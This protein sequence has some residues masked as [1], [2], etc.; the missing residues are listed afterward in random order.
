M[1]TPRNSNLVFVPVPSETHKWTPVI[2]EFTQQYLDDLTSFDDEAKMKL[3]KNLFRSW[4]DC[5]KCPVRKDSVLYDNRRPGERQRL[6][7]GNCPYWDNQPS[8]TTVD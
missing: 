8:K 7:N 3:V 4:T 6:W 5:W 1:P 2:K